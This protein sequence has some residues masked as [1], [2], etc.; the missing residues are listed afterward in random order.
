MNWRMMKLLN[1][2]TQG[3]SSWPGLPGVW[4]PALDS[5]FF[6][7]A[8]GVEAGEEERREGERGHVKRGGSEVHLDYQEC[9]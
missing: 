4:Q 7:M 2:Q 3:H 6:L 5:F 1:Q 9:R 8:L